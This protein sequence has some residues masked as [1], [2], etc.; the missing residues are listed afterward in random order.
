MSIMNTLVRGS[1]LLALVG[2]CA[3]EPTATANGGGRNEMTDNH[4]PRDN[5]TAEY[6]V[7][8]S[9]TEWRAVLTK[10]QY[11]VLREKGTEPPFT[12]KRLHETRPGTYRCA[13]CGQRLF[14]SEAKFTSGT[15]WPS[16]T[17]PVA[18]DHVRLIADRSQGMVRTETVCSRCGG[19]LGHVFADG[20][21]P[22][23]K[24]YC[25]N[26]A[27]LDFQAD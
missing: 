15:G 24:R 5:Q 4:A 18:A 11:R 3:M 27:A 6:A 25:I 19:H 13:G 10:P 1:V 7:Q 16:F 23:G 9:E 20:P 8:R 21:P 14:S 22:T 12:G 2:S 17:Q 26:S